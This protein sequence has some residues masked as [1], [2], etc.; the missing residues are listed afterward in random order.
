MYKHLKKRMSKE[1]AK[2]TATPAISEYS[3][4]AQ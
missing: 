1:L 4:F 2:Y 3:K